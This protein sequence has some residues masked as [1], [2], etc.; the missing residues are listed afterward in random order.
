MSKLKLIVPNPDLCKQIP[1][2][3]FMDSALVWYQDHGEDKVC[4]R[5]QWI[6]VDGMIPVPAPTLDEIINDLPDEYED[7]FLVIGKNYIEYCSVDGFVV[8]GTNF[9]S[10]EDGIADSA[11]MV[12]FK[13]KRIKVKMD[14]RRK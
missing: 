14:E 8:D 10:N 9:C 3:E 13:V 11:I 4:P 12:W 1:D 5:E 2:N 6:G 7:G